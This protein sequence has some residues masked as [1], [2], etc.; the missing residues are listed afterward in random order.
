VVSFNPFIKI[1]YFVVVV[2]PISAARTVQLLLHLTNQMKQI[3]LF[4]LSRPYMLPSILSSETF[5]LETDVF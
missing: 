1:N 4:C 2:L 5:S 3:G